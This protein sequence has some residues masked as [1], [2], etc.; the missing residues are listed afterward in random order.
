MSEEQKIVDT[1]AIENNIEDTAEYVVFTVTAQDGSEVE[2]AVVDEFDFDGKH[3]VVASQVVGDEISD[4]GV[5]I[6]KAK[7]SGDD[8]TVEKITDAKE[9]DAVVKAYTEIEE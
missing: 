4:D 7:M 5:Y 1:N 8:F 2:M 3:Y 9:Y 6:Y